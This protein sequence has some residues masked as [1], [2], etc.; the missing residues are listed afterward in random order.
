[1]GS[2]DCF[3]FMVVLRLWTEIGAVM[4]LLS[5]VRAIFRHDWLE[6]ALYS[7]VLQPFVAWRFLLVFRSWVPIQESLLLDSRLQART[8]MYTGVPKHFKLHED[9]GCA[10]LTEQLRAEFVTAWQPRDVGNL[11]DLVRHRDGML[12]HFE[13]V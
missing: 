8:V 9:V 6:A 12:A 3:S 1:M 11:H 4:V 13:K 5:T 7:F 10:W 2:V